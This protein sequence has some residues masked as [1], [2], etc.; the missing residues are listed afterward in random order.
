MSFQDKYRPR[1]RVAGTPLGKI[2]SHSGVSVYGFLHRTLKGDR[3]AL[4]QEF[5]SAARVLPMKQVQILK[6]SAWTSAPNGTSQAL[7]EYDLHIGHTNFGRTQQDT[8]ALP[9]RETALVVD[10]AI[11][12]TMLVRLGFLVGSMGMWKIDRKDW[13]GN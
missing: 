12:K 13:A 9:C 7:Y 6:V 10:L 8:E 1:H 2:T 4:R 11:M 5:S 3:L